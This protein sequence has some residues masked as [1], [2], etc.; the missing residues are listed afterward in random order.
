MS[1]NPEGPQPTS[2]IEHIQPTIDVEKTNVNV[3]TDGSNDNGF[4]SDKPEEF[5]HG[6][7]RI[8]AITA[9]WSRSTLISMFVLSVPSSKLNLELPLIVFQQALPRRV[10][11]YAP[12]L[13][14]QRS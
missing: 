12:K 8:R 5:Q 10:C 7:E 11:R 1:L 4:E 9:I 13:H 3:H 14:R 2:A 6:V